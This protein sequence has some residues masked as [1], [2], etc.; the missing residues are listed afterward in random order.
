MKKIMLLCLGVLF[1]QAS[2]YAQKYWDS[3]RPDHRFTLGVRMGGNISKFYEEYHFDTRFVTGLQIGMT[4]DVN[5]IRSL[6]ATT[7]LYYIQKN[8]KLEVRVSDATVVRKL[9]PAY[10][11]IPLLLSYRISLSDDSQFQ[12]NLGSYFAVGLTNSD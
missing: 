2:V 11:E 6:S 9:T 10:L 5:I 12:F 1:S 4:M 8:T 7:G 3:S